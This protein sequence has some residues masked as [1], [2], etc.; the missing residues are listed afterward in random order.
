MWIQGIHAR[1]PL[2]E[3]QAYDLFQA[4]FPVTEQCFV[5][6]SDV[7]QFIG[8]KTLRFLGVQTLINISSI[9]CFEK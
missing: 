3:K 5:V 6:N 4:G 2:S 1:I 7:L 9:C 8:F